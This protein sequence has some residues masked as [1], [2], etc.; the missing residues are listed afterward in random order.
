MQNA[1]HGRRSTIEN[2]SGSCGGI[3]ATRQRFILFGVLGSVEGPSSLIQAIQRR[4]EPLCPAKQTR[5][6]VEL[7]PS[8]D[9]MLRA[10]ERLDC[11]LAV[12]RVQVG[13]FF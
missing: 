4:A 8:G 10:L 11:R 2:C 6:A 7:L 3:H 12:G 5:R 1:L 9:D 13:H